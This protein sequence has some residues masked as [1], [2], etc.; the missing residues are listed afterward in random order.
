VGACALR[1]HPK[2]DLNKSRV[3]GNMPLPFV[4]EWDF[5]RRLFYE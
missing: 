4:V 3:V 5:L 1:P 2:A